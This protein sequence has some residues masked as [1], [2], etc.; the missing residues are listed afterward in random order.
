MPRREWFCIGLFVNPSELVLS[1]TYLRLW[2]KVHWEYEDDLSWWWCPESLEVE[3]L[4]DQLCFELG[5][6][7]Q[8]CRRGRAKLW[9]VGEI[10]DDSQQSLA[11]RGNW[12]HI[13]ENC[14]CCWGDLFFLHFSDLGRSRLFIAC[15]HFLYIANLGKLPWVLA[16][17]IY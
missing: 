13:W 17:S 8:G 16:S 6:E 15:S 14:L 4:G 2:S 3:Y 5:P 11:Q 12:C 7:P 10:W 9:E 1:L